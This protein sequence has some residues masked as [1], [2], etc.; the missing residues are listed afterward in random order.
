MRL[1][2]AACLIALF[3]C[4]A[5]ADAGADVMSRLNAP[6]PRVRFDQAVL[7][8]ALE[9]TGESAHVNVSVDWAALQTQGIKQDKP[10]TFAFDHVSAAATFD[11]LCRL[12]GSGATWYVQDGV[13][14]VSTRAQLDKQ[15]VSKSYWPSAIGGPSAERAEKE[16]NI[17]RQFLPDVPGDAIQT[18]NEQVVV[19]G[20]AQTQE[21]AEHIMALCGRPMMP[22]E[23]RQMLG[24]EM[25]LDDSTQKLSI[26][27]QAR[28]LSDC[29]S[30]LSTQTH[31]PM[32]LDP[33]ADP[34]KQITLEMK[35]ASP[36]QVLDGML[37]AAG[38]DEKNRWTC[39][40]AAHGQV[41]WIGPM[42]QATLWCVSCTLGPSA[43]HELHISEPQN[44]PAAICS[45]V[46]GCD[47]NHIVWLGGNHLLCLQP[48]DQIMA[49]GKILRDP[50]F[51][52][53]MRPSRVS[54]ASTAGE[55]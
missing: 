28:P 17:L 14:K 9:I 4:A 6:Q 47:P 2:F 54:N 10:I 24:V 26:S 12:M 30:D 33:S 48:M 40:P 29:I 43:M 13:V 8:D 20:G 44:G 11:V 38:E 50:S 49:I 46:G 51:M 55:K 15:G 34:Q 45:A 3:S 22:A 23:W 7:S 53:A 27:W 42:K 39:E 36:E 18:N 31:T 41:L 52:A 25:D 1:W 5:F 35:N 37:A 21:D 19:H 32:V 16:T